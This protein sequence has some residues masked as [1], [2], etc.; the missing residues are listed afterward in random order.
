ML[1]LWCEKRES[2]Q[3]H[4]LLRE[5]SVSQIPKSFHLYSTSET[6]RPEIVLLFWATMARRETVREVSLLPEI[7]NPWEQRGSIFSLRFKYRG[8]GE[9][10]WGEEVA[11]SK[12]IPNKLRRSRLGGGWTPTLGSE[13]ERRSPPTVLQAEVEQR[14]PQEGHVAC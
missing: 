10:V 11:G 5:K 2:L 13:L 14:Q 7:E 9:D 12:R 4:A 1:E 8:E 3:P 6:W